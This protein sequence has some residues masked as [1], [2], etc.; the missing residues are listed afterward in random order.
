M[1]MESRKWF[2]WTYLQGRNRDTDIDSRPV[3]AAEGEGR[4]GWIEESHWKM[5]ITICKI[6]SLLEVAA[7]YREP[8]L[9]LCDNLEG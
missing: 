4:V 7:W 1:Y 6:D 2:W 9:V 5:D 8:N 3:D